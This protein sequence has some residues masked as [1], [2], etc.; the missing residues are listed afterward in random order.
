MSLPSHFSL[1]PS[2]SHRTSTRSGREGGREDTRSVGLSVYA[3]RINAFPDVT[4]CREGRPNLYPSALRIATSGGSVIRLL[5]PRRSIFLPLGRFTEPIGVSSFWRLPNKVFCRVKMFPTR[6]SLL[7]SYM[8]FPLCSGRVTRGQTG[9]GETDRP[10]SG[11]RRRVDRDRRLNDAGAGGVVERT[12]KLLAAR[13]REGV[14]CREGGGPSALQNFNSGLS[15]RS[16]RRREPPPSSEKFVSSESDSPSPPHLRW[17]IRTP[18]E[19][20]GRTEEPRSLSLSFSFRRHN[21]NFSKLR[22]PPPP[23]ASGSKLSPSHTAGRS[24][25]PPRSFRRPHA[26]RLRRRLLL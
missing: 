14:S 4:L 23:P 25:V 24:A 21:F 13:E 7:W 17:T 16:F 18:D 1:S 11:G 2:P 6:F 12:E 5:C 3:P 19:R 26:P 9:R 15:V 8:I 20:H 22:L 10:T